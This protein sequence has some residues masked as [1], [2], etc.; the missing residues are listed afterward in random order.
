MPMI[1]AVAGKN[2]QTTDIVLD[3][4]ETTVAAKELGDILARVEGSIKAGGGICNIKDIMIREE[5]NYVWFYIH[6][7]PGGTD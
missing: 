5:E 4:S 6:N 1:S 2:S 7:I 3:L